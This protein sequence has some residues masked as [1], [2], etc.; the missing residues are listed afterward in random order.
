[1]P[2]ISSSRRFLQLDQ[3]PLLL[4]NAEPDQFGLGRRELGIGRRLRRLPPLRARC[5][6]SEASPDRRASIKRRRQHA[7]AGQ[8]PPHLAANFTTGELAYLKVLA[9]EF[10]AHGLCDLSVNETASRRCL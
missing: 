9:D 10:L 2:T 5:S 8:L 4:G 6:R 7:A 1:M 3:L